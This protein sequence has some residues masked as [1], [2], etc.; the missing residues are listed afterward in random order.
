MSM[1]QS[2]PA[3]RKNQGRR[4]LSLIRQD[5]NPQRQELA[6]YWLK[7]GFLIDIHSGT[8]PKG[9][10]QIKKSSADFLLRRAPPTKNKHLPRWANQEN[11]LRGRALTSCFNADRRACNGS[12]QSQYKRSRQQHRS[13]GRHPWL[14]SGRR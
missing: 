13:Q 6:Q 1:R 8:N 11:M 2:G 4:R 9:F 7:S 14:R 12:P 3:Q 10:F 5:H